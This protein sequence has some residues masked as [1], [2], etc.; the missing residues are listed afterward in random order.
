MVDILQENKDVK[1][2]VGKSILAAIF[3][4][5]INDPNEQQRQLS[6]LFSLSQLW[7]QPQ[8]AEKI[9]QVG[10]N[11]D[12]EFESYEA[13]LDH[14]I[15]HGQDEFFD[16]LIERRIVD[17]SS[18]FTRQRLLQHYDNVFVHKQS[19]KLS[20]SCVYLFRDI[21]LKVSPG[22]KLDWHVRLSNKGMA[23]AVGDSLAL[24]CRCGFANFFTQIP[25]VSNNQFI[26][27]LSRRGSKPVANLEDPL[28]KHLFKPGYDNIF[29]DLMLFSLLLKRRRFAEVVWRDSSNHL[30]GALMASVFLK[31]LA[32]LAKATAMTELAN[33][34]EEEAQIWQQ[35]LL[36]LLSRC[37]D[38]KPHLCHLML[39]RGLDQWQDKN[40]LEIGLQ[41][42]DKDLISHSA[43]QAM[44]GQ[45]WHG[46]IASFTPLYLIY[47]VAL[48]PLFWPLILKFQFTR[49]SIWQWSESSNA[50]NSTTDIEEN[51]DSENESDDNASVADDDV[52]NEA[53]L[54]TSFK[55]LNNKSNRIGFALA[56]W[57]LY[58]APN[59][60]LIMHAM[61]T[62]VFL[63]FFTF[64]ILTSFGGSIGFVECFIWIWAL[65]ILI[66]DVDMTRF[67]MESKFLAANSAFSMF[68]F[69]SVI[70]NMLVL[71]AFV[72]RLTLP[73]EWYVV[74]HTSYCLS[75]LVFWVD[76]LRFLLVIQSLGPKVMMLFK[77]FQEL[78]FFLII[79]TMLLFAFAVSIH[80]LLHPRNEIS[81]VSDF[82]SVLVQVVYFRW[83][84]LAGVGL[85]E[86]RSEVEGEEER[87]ALGQ[88]GLTTG[89]NGSNFSDASPNSHPLPMAAP[90]LLSSSSL[91][92]TSYQKHLLVI[93]ST[94]GKHY[95]VVTAILLVIYL[96]L[97]NILLLNMLI[98]LLSM[99]VEEV[100]VDSS[101]LWRFSA[102]KVAT[103]FY[104]KRAVPPPFNLPFFVAHLFVFLVAKLTKSK[105]KTKNQQ[106]NFEQDSDFSKFIFLLELI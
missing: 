79:Y 1:D 39:V 43:V 86:T 3:R 49:E 22:N 65:A 84:N 16:L 45:I 63:L 4:A 87:E 46:R 77:M 67:G 70:A 32:Q 9:I 89:L 25:G 62:L 27:K 73:T 20:R 74:C 28:L 90:T 64:F 59:V 76:S 40:I 18:T 80:S 30:G 99:K 105:N 57:Y 52:G 34:Y 13:A 106:R 51:Q 48:C 6:Q 97:T 23:K 33:D 68:N 31:N 8:M 29:R 78:L 17:L 88:V 71:V 91:P 55:P 11:C 100:K 54:K 26:P 66:E 15:E 81:S 5:H 7:N 61:S 82:F 19:A 102:F 41:S 60:K 83:W 37:Y 47:L 96:I 69:G 2:A 38:A 50:D 104:F 53:F 14:S 75:C 85:D 12:F 95:H 24:I 56:L 58:Q 72:C 10:T 36:D 101:R 103:R 42:F 44:L 92:I 94:S 98:A 35:R 93:D 21:M